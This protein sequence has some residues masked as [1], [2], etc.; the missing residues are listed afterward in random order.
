M[1][2]QTYFE[3]TKSESL[4]R[5]EIAE[6]IKRL[7]E[8][9]KKL[10][11]M[12]IHPQI[13]M[14]ELNQII[15]LAENPQVKVD[16]VTNIFADLFYDFRVTALF[17][18]GFLKMN[19]YI[20]PFELHINQ[21]VML[22]ITHDYAGAIHLLI[23]VIEGSLRKYLIDVKGKEDKAIMRASEQLK[24]F[25]FLKQ[26]YITT[27]EPEFK[28]E[29]DA[30]TIDK[31]QYERLI[32][33]ELKY[34]T[35]WYEM[36]ED[37]LRHNL[38]MDTSKGQLEDELNRHVLVHGFESQ[39]DYNLS[40]FLKVFNAIMYVAWAFQISDP[41]IPQRVNVENDEILYKWAAFEK[42]NLL[43]AI[44]DPIKLSAYSKCADFD[45]NSFKFKPTRPRFSPL[46]IQKPIEHQL[47][48]VDS[49][50]N[51]LFPGTRNI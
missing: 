22:A 35:T 16:Q 7:N 8:E 15:K 42:L 25:G 49:M 26:D 20:A 37:Y 17:I 11:W 18:D 14:S 33:L 2:N 34:I 45:T 50:I 40:N 51:V 36:I 32:D 10:N 19:K 39:V 27:K 12:F 30:G 6:E 47:G 24:V 1:S 46:D 41:S 23:P 21:A 31:N 38:Y 13:F 4:G 48:K 5:I 29:L 43:T 3:K 44:T 28:R 9:L